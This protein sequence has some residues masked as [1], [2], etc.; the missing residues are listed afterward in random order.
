MI[1][2]ISWHDG[3]HVLGLLISTGCDVAGLIACSQTD[4][5][6]ALLGAAPI[7]GDLSKVAFAEVGIDDWSP[8][9]SPQDGASWR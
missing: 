4:E 9:T 7:A 5:S 1:T 6:D 8:M 3:G 2:W